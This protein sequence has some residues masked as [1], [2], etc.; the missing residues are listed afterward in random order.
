MIDIIEMTLGVQTQS[1]FVATVCLIIVVNCPR[2][3]AGLRFLASSL[4]LP[5]ASSSRS[6]PAVYFT[7]VCFTS[8][9]FTSVCFSTVCFTAV[10]LTSV[11]ITAVLTQFVFSLLHCRFTSRQYASLKFE[12]LFPF[13][14]L[15]FSHSCVLNTMKG[16]KK[17]WCVLSP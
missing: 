10:C 6:L 15:H 8:V 1:V 7:S 16:F 11:C 13:S 12:V 14:S 5:P 3:S 17:G 4:L 9:C 2:H